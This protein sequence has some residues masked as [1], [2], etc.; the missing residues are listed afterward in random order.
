MSCIKQF[1]ILCSLT[2][3]KDL[4]AEAQ[5]KKQS[6][7]VMCL[8]SQSFICNLNKPSLSARPHSR[9]WILL[10]GPCPGECVVVWFSRNSTQLALKPVLSPASSAS[11]PWGKP[12]PTSK[13]GRWARWLRRYL[14]SSFWMGSFERNFNE[15]F[16][17][18][19]IH[20]EFKKKKK[21]PT[22]EHKLS[23][24]HILL[25]Y[26]STQQFSEV[27]TDMPSVESRKLSRSPMVK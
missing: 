1:T 19:P 27:G 10:L 9:C 16:T 26:Q 14:T 25:S 24:L 6:P 20:N 3:Q 2:L 5:N 23:I 13:W 8:T 17:S 22:L 15:C 7:L 4:E 18:F 11:H 12:L 21:T